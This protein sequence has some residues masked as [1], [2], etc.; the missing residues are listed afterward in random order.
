MIIVI[1]KTLSFIPLL[2]FIFLPAARVI[3]VPKE[4]WNLRLIAVGW[5]W[6]VLG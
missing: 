4:G 3:D 5:L 1:W 6:I 2:P